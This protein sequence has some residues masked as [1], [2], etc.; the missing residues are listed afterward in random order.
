MNISAEDMETL[1][2]GLSQGTTASILA[3]HKSPDTLAQMA[4]NH[5]LDFRRLLGSLECVQMYLDAG[6]VS[7]A[8]KVVNDGLE[9]YQLIASIRAKELQV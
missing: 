7:E 3:S 5:A 4:L 6:K 1:E 2:H 8:H 9:F